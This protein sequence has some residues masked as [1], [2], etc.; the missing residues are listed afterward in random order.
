MTHPASRSGA[1]RLPARTSAAS[2]RGELVEDHH[3]RDLQDALVRT[4]QALR[5]LVPDTVTVAELAA[6]IGT[7]AHVSPQLART[8]AYRLIDCGDLMFVGSPQARSPRVT[9][10]R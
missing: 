6:R 10:S 7:H 1:S 8:V 4:R 3:R 2:G 5:A 9:V